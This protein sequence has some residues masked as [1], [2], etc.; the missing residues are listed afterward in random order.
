VLLA[1]QALIA[2]PVGVGWGPGETMILGA[3]LLWSIEVVLAK[4]L[5]AGVSAPLLAASRMGLGLVVLVGYL[6]V[7]GRIGGLATLSPDAWLWVMVTGGLLSAYVITW[8]SALRHA[9]A[10]VVTSLLV[11]AA[12]ITGVLTSAT[13]GKSPSPTVVAGYLLVL[14]AVAAI[15]LVA[16]RPRSAPHARRDPALA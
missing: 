8:Y 15:A 5:L 14:V 11:A 16:A 7:S 4:R 2:P 3:T 6:V 10:T 1:G 13:T 9:P 12:V